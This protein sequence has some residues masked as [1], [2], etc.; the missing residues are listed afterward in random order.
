MPRSDSRPSRAPVR[1]RERPTAAGRTSRP[2]RPHTMPTMWRSRRWGKPPP[3]T[4]ATPSWWPRSTLAR[5]PR[6]L[7]NHA[8][9]RLAVHRDPLGPHLDRIRR[10][11][12]HDGDCRAT[13]ARW[14][15][16][17]D[18]HPDGGGQ[19]D[20]PRAVARDP[21][22]YVAMR[23]LVSRF[24]D[25]PGSGPASCRRRSRSPM[26]GAPGRP[27]GPGRRHEQ[28][29]AS[30]RPESLL[31]RSAVQGSGPSRETS[32]R[33]ASF[34]SLQPA[35]EGL[36]GDLGGELLAMPRRAG[37]R[38]RQWPAADRSAE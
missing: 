21:R 23:M 20:E 33:D 32:Q 5:G 10:S 22:E 30:S 34:A 14:T 18:F 3:P 12:N 1:R 19:H 28:N 4:L 31:D 2:P 35:R 15:R 24:T 16:D 38:H 25:G 36:T 11:G 7:V 17:R 26:V 37:R 6:G 29:Q 8:A 13:L 27:P 9:R